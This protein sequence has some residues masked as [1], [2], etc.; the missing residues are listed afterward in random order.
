MHTSQPQRIGRRYL[1]L[2]AATLVGA[3]W[4]AWKY[5]LNLPQTTV[6]LL[7]T[8]AASYMT[9]AQF[10]AGRQ[11]AASAA[12]GQVTLGQLA[13]Q[14]AIA[15]R[16]QWEA[17]AAH[18]RLN[19]P[20]PLPV[21]WQPA[22][23][24]L[25]ETWHDLVTTARGWPGRPPTDPAT[26]ATSPADLAGADNDLA[27]VLARVP[28]GRLVVLGEPGAGKTM[29]LVRLLLDLLARRTP[30]GPVPVL[31]P[32]AAWN[33]VD[34]DLATWLAQRLVLDHPGLTAPAPPGAGATTRVQALL[35]HRL[36]LPI[37]DGLD[38]LPERMVGRAI[39]H[40][41]TA[42][43]PGQGL[44]LASR[45]GAYRHAITGQPNPTGQPAG[46]E[47]GSVPVRLWGAAGITLRP[48]AP[49]D[50]RAYLRRDAAS[51]TMAARWNPVLAALGT[52]TPLGQTLVTPLTVGLARTIY[53]PRPGEHPTAVPDPAELCD[54][55][56][57]PTATTIQA[58][59]FDAFIPAAYRPHPDPRRRGRWTADQ[60]GPW[61]VFLARH[62]HDRND[63]TDI[64]WWQLHHAIPT[65]ML[66]LGAGL[67]AGLWAGLV[68][69]LVVGLV[70][71]LGTGVWAGVVVGVVVV[72]GLAAGRGEVTPAKGLR[73]FKDA[74]A[75]V[76]G[77]LVAGL[78]VGLVGGLLFG[79][80][81][82]H[83]AGPRAVQLGAGLVLGIR[84]W[85]PFGLLLGLL[86]AVAG[87]MSAFKG[88]PTD[89]TITAD[90]K[91]VL[92]RDRRAFLTIGLAGGLAVGGLAVGGLVGGLTFGLGEGL[93]VG[94]GLGLGLGLVVGLWQAAWGWFGLVRCWLALRR[95][96]PWRLMTFLADAHQRGVLRQAGAVYQFRHLELQRRLAS[97]QRYPGSAPMWSVGWHTGL[98]AVLMLQ[99]SAVGWSGQAL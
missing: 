3:V 97:R 44:V 53:N 51:P 30:G 45:T 43:P 20:H 47:P 28:T 88:T 55:A 21:G 14:L 27:D 35:E 33:P 34:H 54:Q 91:T 8:I 49:V 7:P 70:V 57:F 84:L 75:G 39:S 93:P 31:V 59:L 83:Q 9:W 72:L 46:Q 10:R 82:W 50:V 64:A 86:G 13:D 25:V 58:H 48:L 23:P 24:S 18:Q 63:T 6:A 67:V 81:A 61:L 68:A 29:L 65:P 95:R 40:L 5:E 66:G 52:N 92:T 11:D 32:L 38:E 26:W 15:V 17:E 89:L 79:L 76:V 62:L 12:A 60:A 16:A 77:G 96:L 41:N 94:L 71:G 1:A 74:L 36:L 87:L 90:P 2:T 80:V 99:V 73:W 78:A 4:V 37:L 98:V 22:D 56:R 42:L 19:D 85:F 69:G